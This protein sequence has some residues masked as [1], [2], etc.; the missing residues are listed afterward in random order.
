MATSPKTPD[1][2]VGRD[3]AAWAPQGGGIE[4]DVR[5]VADLGAVGELLEQG[6]EAAEAVVRGVS[7]PKAG[8]QVAPR[9]TGTGNVQGGLPG[10]LGRRPGAW[11]RRRDGRSGRRGASGRPTWRW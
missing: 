3:S 4:E 6:T 7:G 11:P 9:A 8:G 5:Q 1:P 2:N 10:R